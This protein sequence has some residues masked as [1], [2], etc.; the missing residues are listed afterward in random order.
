MRRNRRKDRG[1]IAVLAS[2]VLLAVGAF[3]ALALNVG[4]IMNTRGQLQNAS[5][6]AAL[7]AAGSIDGTQGGLNT[8]RQM[9][10]GYSGNHEVTGQSVA[11]D[12]GADVV[13]G[14]WHFKAESGWPARSFEVLSD[15]LLI[16]AVRITNGRDD[17]NG[18]NPA[19]DVFFSVWLGR[20]KVNV[21][22]QAIAIGRGARNEDCPLP[23]VLP[24]CSLIQGGAVTCGQDITL[25]L[26][27]DGT[28][29]VGFVF[30][31]PGN[32]NGVTEIVDNI[33][34]RCTVAATAGVYDVQNGNDLNDQ[35]MQALL[36][37]D[38]HG[39]Q[40]SP[41]GPTLPDGSSSLCIFNRS[42]SFP[43]GD[44]TCPD[45]KFS[46]DLTVAQYASVVIKSV[47]T[48][49]KV[50]G[51][52]PTAP[53]KWQDYY[54]TLPN[55]GSPARKIVLNVVCG[56]GNGLAFNNAEVLRLVQ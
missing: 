43:I 6:S 4:L 18:H 32:G 31:L 13:F 27:P 9:A 24:S 40:M 5:D 10:L 45:P 3:M 29:N 37:L 26:S 39:N 12:P 34:N 22:S 42:D 56:T 46:G 8:A 14:R 25:T 54:D 7:A 49:G 17:V 2:V 20:E 19:L 41:V 35:V 11:I 36:G 21:P 48:G 50:Y 52:C 44:T 28:D 33:L 16:D 1:A 23:F 38:K 47:S 51:S 30:M 53:V 55:E 15:P